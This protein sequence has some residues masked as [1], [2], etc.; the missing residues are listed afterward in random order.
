MV[1]YLEKEDRKI[2]KVRDAHVVQ[3]QASPHF[4]LRLSNGV[5]LESTAPVLQTIGSINSPNA[6]PRPVTALPAAELQALVSARPLSWVIFN[7]GDQRIVFSNKWHLDLTPGPNDTWQ[8]KA[9]DN[10]ILTYPPN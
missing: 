5:T 1:E 2:L 7:T 10:D 9:N 4:L 3:I 6:S 8:L